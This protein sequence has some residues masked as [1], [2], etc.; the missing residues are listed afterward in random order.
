MADALAD[1]IA[2]ALPPELR[3][4]VTSVV[5]RDVLRQIEQR[6]WRV[7]SAESTRVD[8][9]WLADLLAEMELQRQV[10]TTAAPTVVAAAYA[11][12]RSRVSLY[13]D[14]R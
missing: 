1:M 13:R 7:E 3:H 6:G 2:Q 11:R 5:G 8:S 14:S 10:T 9:E 4:R 12:L